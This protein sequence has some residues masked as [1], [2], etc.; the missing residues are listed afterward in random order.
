MVLAML[1][2]LHPRAGLSLFLHLILAVALLHSQPLRSQQS[3][4]EAFSAPLELSQPLS[5]LVDDYGILP[6]HPWPRG[7]RPL[8]SRAQ[9]RKRDG[10]DLAE[11]YYDAHL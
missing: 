6:K 10:P 2:A 3:V 1:G 5:G 7:P 9:Q 8:L 11:Y 4:P